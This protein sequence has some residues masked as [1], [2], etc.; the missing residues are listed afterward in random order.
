MKPHDVSPTIDRTGVGVLVLRID[1]YLETIVIRAY[2]TA[3]FTHFCSDAGS[4][5]DEVRIGA[6]G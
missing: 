3:V 2:T 6:S 5:E 4:L 1:I